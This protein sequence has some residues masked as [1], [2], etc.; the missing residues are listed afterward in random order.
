MGTLEVMR[1][2]FVRARDYKQAWDDLQG[3]ED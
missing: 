2:A 3:K 1:D